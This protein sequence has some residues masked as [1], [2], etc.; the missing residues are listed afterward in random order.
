MQRTRSDQRSDRATKLQRW[1]QTAIRAWWTKVAAGVIFLAA[2][3]TILVNLQTIRGWFNDDS[4]PVEATGGDTTSPVQIAPDRGED[5]DEAT[6]PERPQHAVLVGFS[7][8]EL[9]ARNGL[10]RMLDTEDGQVLSRLIG[11]YGFAS[12]S[13]LSRRLKSPG[14]RHS[15][16]DLSTLRLGR[17]HSMAREVEIHALGEDRVLVLVNV[18]RGDAA[19]LS[20]PT[21]NVG[22]VFGF[23]FDGDEARPVMVGV[24]VSRIR[25]WQARTQDFA[26]IDV[27]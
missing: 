8:A 14:S 20:D 27:K 1:F 17:E 7:R 12:H 16:L 5:A 25:T 10:R 22:E 24:P 3:T 26:A 21:G 19:R 15:D 13:S 18:S 9:R 2:L 4:R 11:V 6:A 23:F